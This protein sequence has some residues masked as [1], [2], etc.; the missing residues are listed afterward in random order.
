LCRESMPEPERVWVRT[1]RPE[2]AAY[3]QLFTTLTAGQLPYAP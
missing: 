3:W 2:A 1:H